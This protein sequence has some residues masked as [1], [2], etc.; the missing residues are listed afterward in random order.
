[1]GSPQG[2]VDRDAAGLERAP[3]RP[4]RIEAA[5][6]TRPATATDASGELAGE[7]LEHAPE[8]GQF[9]AR[10]RQDGPVESTDRQRLIVT[11][12]R[13]REPALGDLVGQRPPELLECPGD[14]V[15]AERQLELRQ[16]AFGTEPAHHGR[17]HVGEVE[18]AHDAVD[19]EPVGRIVTAVH[20]H[21]AG[22]KGAH[23]VAVA[24]R[25]RGADVGRE[26]RGR[27]SI[28][29]RRRRRRR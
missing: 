12:A 21:C 28:Q 18:G 9:G 3:E 6:R 1:M 2:R 7:R 23:R 8:L 13:R 11:V 20:R 22:G 27:R 25:G 26:G 17:E 5:R 19:H 24:A 14:L 29:S 15:A 16:I 10:Q 4:A